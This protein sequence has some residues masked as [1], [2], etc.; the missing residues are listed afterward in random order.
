[1]NL[2]IIIIVKLHTVCAA[3]VDTDDGQSSENGTQV[4]INQNYPFS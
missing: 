2:A 4:V 3:S 1:M